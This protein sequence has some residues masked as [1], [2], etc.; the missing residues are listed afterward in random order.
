LAEGRKNKINDDDGKEARKK[1][2]TKE[3]KRTKERTKEII[4]LKKYMV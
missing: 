2:I 3:R 4:Y 1:N